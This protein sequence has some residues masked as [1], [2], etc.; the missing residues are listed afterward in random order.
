MQEKVGTKKEVFK[1]YTKKCGKR[2]GGFNANSAGNIP[3]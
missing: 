3:K 1:K 2:R